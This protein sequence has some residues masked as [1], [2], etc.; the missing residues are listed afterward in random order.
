MIR[1]VGNGMIAKVFN[2]FKSDST[3]CL[4]F[5]SG[6]S[7]STCKDPNQFI[8]EELLLKN[9]LGIFNLKDLIESS[10]NKKLSK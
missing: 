1:I 9:E 7:D 4:I 10:K 5:A 6:V 2:N 8:R 3:N